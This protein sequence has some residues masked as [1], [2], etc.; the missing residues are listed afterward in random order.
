LATLLTTDI[1]LINRLT[2]TTSEVFFVNQM[3]VLDEVYKIRESPTRC[4]DSCDLTP[5]LKKKGSTS[6]HG[7]NDLYF[8]EEHL[9]NN[10]V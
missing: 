9:L 7:S 2:E 3:T 10:I 4:G 1:R 5:I 6:S 8:P